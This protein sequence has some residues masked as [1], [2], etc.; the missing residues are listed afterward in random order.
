MNTPHVWVKL[1]QKRASRRK[2]IPM[3]AVTLTLV[4]H[5]NEMRVIKDSIGPK[6]N[7]LPTEQPLPMP[8]GRFCAP[9]VFLFF[10]ERL[11]NF[12]SDII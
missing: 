5:N 8:H 6:T 10:P 2:T 4:S 7:F 9:V 3:E 11:S 12:L 1:I